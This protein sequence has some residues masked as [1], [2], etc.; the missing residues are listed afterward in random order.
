MPVV[1]AFDVD[2]T[3]TTRDCV[4]P[5]LRRAAGMRLWTTILRHPVALGASLVHRDRDRLKE[6][7]CSALRGR[8][9]AELD[10]LG[11]SFAGE[12]ASDGCATTQR[13]GCG[14]TGSSAT[15]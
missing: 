1:A 9:A 3:L 11:T 15:R 6:L 2:G 14:G 10:R 5:F 12:V 4:T 8:D 7:A 13:R